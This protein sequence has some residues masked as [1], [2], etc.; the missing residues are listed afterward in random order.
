MTRQ[1]RDGRALGIADSYERRVRL[2]VIRTQG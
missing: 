2:G 1:V